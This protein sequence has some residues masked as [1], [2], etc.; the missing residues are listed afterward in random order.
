MTARSSHHAT[1]TI[2]RTYP[3]PP[4]RVFAAWSSR[5]AKSQ[6]FGMPDDGSYQLDFRVGGRESNRGGPPGGLV[7][8]YDAEYLDIVPDERIIYS[9][10]M[11]AGENR[12]SASVTTVEFALDGDGTKL[13]FTEQGV[14]LDGHDTP[15]LRQGGTKELLSALGQAL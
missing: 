5:E 7:Y 3:A 10:A 2:E 1:F 8:T 13:I 4:S 9:Y 15:D 11:N 12:I 6:W 14:Y